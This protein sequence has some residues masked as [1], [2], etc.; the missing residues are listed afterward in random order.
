MLYS[1]LQ[2]LLQPLSPLLDELIRAAHEEGGFP[3]QLW[4][5][6]AG[7]ERRQQLR[8]RSSQSKETQGHH[9]SSSQ[10]PGAQVSCVPAW[11]FHPHVFREHLG[12][13]GQWKQRLAAGWGKEGAQGM[14]TPSQHSSGA[15]S[16][17]TRIHGTGA[18][19]MR[20]W[21]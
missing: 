14:L 13:P 21:Q 12:S 16:S 19:H 3:R 8:V 11:G 1:L 17:A 5:R 9:D 2:E 18:A 4:D 6:P 15:A 10:D 20:S 7:T